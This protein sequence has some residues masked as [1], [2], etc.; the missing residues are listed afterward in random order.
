MACP[1]NSSSAIGSKSLADCVCQEGYIKFSSSTCKECP[2]STFQDG[3][4][5]LPCPPHTSSPKGS[6]HI[7]NCT[8]TLDCQKKNWHPVVETCSGHCYEP[9]QSCQACQA[10][11]VKD[12]FSTTGNFD[13]CEPCAIG[14]YQYGSHIH[15]NLCLPTRSTSS[16]AKNSIEDCLC[17]PGFEEIV[18]SPDF[19][20]SSSYCIFYAL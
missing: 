11:F 18:T 9:M 2:E 17:L 16:T 20:T 19:Q 13:K 5:C 15:C 1:L 7:N 14:T 4:V 6:T 3:N 10:G 8:C 12:T